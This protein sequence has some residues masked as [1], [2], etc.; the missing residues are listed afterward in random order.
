MAIFALIVT[1][2]FFYAYRLAVGHHGRGDA[3]DN[4]DWCRDGSGLSVRL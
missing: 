4:L 1:C 2:W 3:S